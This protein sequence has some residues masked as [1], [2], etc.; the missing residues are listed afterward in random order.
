MDTIN[1]R[2]LV[3]VR[4]LLTDSS[5]T[6]ECVLSVMNLIKLMIRNLRWLI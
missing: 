1:N 5:N 3:Y 6:K 2:L 4:M